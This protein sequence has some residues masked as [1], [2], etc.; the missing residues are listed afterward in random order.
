MRDNA[1]VYILHKYGA[2]NRP[3]VYAL[4]AFNSAADDCRT[5]TDK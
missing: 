3:K 2:K 4:K 1:Y 5:L